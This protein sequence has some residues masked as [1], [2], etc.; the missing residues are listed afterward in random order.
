MSAADGKV[1]KLSLFATDRD[2]PLEVDVEAIEP[3]LLNVTFERKAPQGASGRVQFVASVEVPRG[4]TPGRYV[5]DNR[6]QVRIKTNHPD[7]PLVRL[8]VE[9]QAD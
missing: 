5:D 3:P 9:L 1:V 8:N 6:I 4:I 7:A 2:P